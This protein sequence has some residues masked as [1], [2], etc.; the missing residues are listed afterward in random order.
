MRNPREGPT[1]NV[2]GCADS[3]V[4]PNV[5]AENVS[6]IDL[7]GENLAAELRQASG[8]LVHVKRAAGA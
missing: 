7:P 8:A 5:N 6:V 4:R 3:S 1:R 2:T